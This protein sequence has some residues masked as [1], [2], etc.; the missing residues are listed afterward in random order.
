MA[1]DK[2]IIQI[3]SFEDFKKYISQMPSWDHSVQITL[4]WK[5]LEGN[6]PY[7]TEYIFNRKSKMIGTKIK[8]Y[9]Y[10]CKCRSKGG[11]YDIIGWYYKK[12][13]FDELIQEIIQFF[14]EKVEHIEIRNRDDVYTISEKLKEEILNNKEMGLL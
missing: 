4:F 3:D 14:P 13:S 11:I 2:N 5:K 1:E 12:L 8:K 6:F 10:F 7:L 9:W